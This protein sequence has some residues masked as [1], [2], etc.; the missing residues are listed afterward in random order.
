MDF[1]VNILKYY[2]EDNLCILTAC[3]KQKYE[4]HILQMQCANTYNALKKENTSVNNI[5]I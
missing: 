5:N 3:E 4:G 2:F 1:K